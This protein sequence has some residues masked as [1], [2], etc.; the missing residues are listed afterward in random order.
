LLFAFISFSILLWKFT[1]KALRKQK[2]IRLRRD[3][4]ILRKTVQVLRSAQSQRTGL[5]T[6]W[7]ALTGRVVAVKIEADGDI[8]IALQD[9]T[10]DKPGVVVV[11]IPAKPQ[12]CELRKIVFAWTEVVFPFRVGSGRKLKFRQP[13]IITVVGKAFFDV[14]HAPADHSN[15]R[16]NSAFLRLSATTSQPFI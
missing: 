13:L 7:F 16:L 11:E 15:R 6:K 3:P 5:E 10:G 9:V 4:L 2:P 1:D 12:W 8:H 14:G